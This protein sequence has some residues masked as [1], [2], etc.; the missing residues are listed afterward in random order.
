MGWFAA[1][2]LALALFVPAA[3][4]SPDVEIRFDA[5]SHVHKVRIGDAVVLAKNAMLTLTA[6]DEKARS[7]EASFTGSVSVIV[8]VEGHSLQCQ[9]ER[10]SY[11]FD[12]EA[13]TFE[14]AVLRG[15]KDGQKPTVVCAEKMTL[16][17]R[18]LRLK[19]E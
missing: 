18:A 11:S 5:S 19:A 13:W 8:Q 17:P 7:G 9:C 10:A 6:G 2:T 12:T 4:E 1:C 3:N 15:T 14:K 16:N